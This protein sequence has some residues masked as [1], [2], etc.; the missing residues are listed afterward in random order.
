M[1]YENQ[2]F[3]QC[4]FAD[5]SRAQGCA[6]NLTLFGGNGTEMYRILRTEDEDK[7]CFN[8]NNQLRAYGDIRIFDIEEDGTN[9]NIGLTIDEPVNVSMAK[10]FKQMPECRTGRVL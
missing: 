7:K 1:F 8:I 2:L 10:T 3:L 6:V 4:T 5:D 9:G